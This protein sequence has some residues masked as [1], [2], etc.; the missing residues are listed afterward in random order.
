MMMKFKLKASKLKLKVKT[1][2]GSSKGEDASLGS[3]RVPLPPPL[4]PRKKPKI[5]GED[6]GEDEG[7]DGEDEAGI[8][9][10]DEGGRHLNQHALNI[11]ALMSC[12][13]HTH[14]LTSWRMTSRMRDD[15]EDGDSHMRDGVASEETAPSMPEIFSRQGE[16][17]TDED[18]GGAVE[19]E[20]PRLW[21]EG[22]GLDDW[23]EEHEE[24]EEQGLDDWEEQALEEAE[25]G[26]LDDC[27]EAEEQAE[28]QALEE[29]DGSEISQVE[30]PPDWQP[31]L[32]V[33][34]AQKGDCTGRD[35]GKR[36]P[37]EYSPCRFYFNTNRGCFPHLHANHTCPFSHAQ[38]WTTAPYATVLAN[39]SW[40]RW[41]TPPVKPQAMHWDCMKPRPPDR[42]LH[43]PC[44]TFSPA[45][46][47]RNVSPSSSSRIPAPRTHGCRRNS[48]GNPWQRR[49]PK[50]E[51]NEDKEKRRKREVKSWRE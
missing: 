32:D 13:M 35:G 20:A 29:Q 23:D 31:W 30:I 27:D 40:K 19:E 44:E 50:R 17:G 28:E 46:H 34:M 2:A 51:S 42:M 3:R 5:E 11:H 1:A 6:E 26:G 21:G 4:P 9:G 38:G 7:G 10:E 43:I 12:S 47:S 16:S 24:W 25:G 18:E 49:P 39:L 22:D 45:R 48:A 14:A 41:R 33:W 36:I 8:E 37:K 15:E